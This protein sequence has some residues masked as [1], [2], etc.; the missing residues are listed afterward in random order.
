MAMVLLQLPVAHNKRLVDG[1][2]CRECVREKLR[3]K[4]HAR[5]VLRAV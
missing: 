4:R 5:C 2:L 3:G 1:Y